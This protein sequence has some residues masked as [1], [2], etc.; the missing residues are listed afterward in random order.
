[1][2]GMI[3]ALLLVSC[4]SS[5]APGIA[6]SFL[7]PPGDSDPQELHLIRLFDRAGESVV[8]IALRIHC[9]CCEREEVKVMG[10]GIGWGNGLVITCAHVLDEPAPVEVYLRNGTHH[11]ATVVG[12]ASKLDVAVLRLETELPSLPL[13]ASRDLR[14]GQKVLAMGHPFE[15]GLSLSV[16]YVGGIEREL[17]L[18]TGGRLKN[19]IQV[20]AAINPGFSGGPLLDSHGR[21]IGIMA[22]S[23]DRTGI[24]F[25]IP[26][27]T[28]DGVAKELLRSGQWNEEDLPRQ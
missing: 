22:A 14:V 7:V 3:P 18:V 28:I 16:G 4:T 15:L 6:P 8:A 10:T 12:K 1:M 24:G 26:V 2:K 20:D 25:A 17:P 5:A 27:E 9:K 13:G 19:L 23:I 21:L 11:K